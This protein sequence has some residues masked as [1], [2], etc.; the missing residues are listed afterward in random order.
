MAPGKGLQTSDSSLKWLNSLLE[1]RAKNVRASVYLFFDLQARGS[2]NSPFK[3]EW[4]TRAI[5]EDTLRLN[6]SLTDVAVSV[7]LSTGVESLRRMGEGS[8]A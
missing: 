1:V 5:L 3:V 6:E 8:R 4:S 7:T 2:L